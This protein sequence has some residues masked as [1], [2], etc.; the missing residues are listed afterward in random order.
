MCFN[1]LHFW[2]SP[3]FYF[4]LLGLVLDLRSHCL[5]N[6]NGF[7]FYSDGIEHSLITFSVVELLG[8]NNFREEEQDFSVCIF[9]NKIELIPY[10]LETEVIISLQLFELYRHFDIFVII[11][12]GH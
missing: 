3:S 8:E 5:R 4:L 2:W 7:C 10:M 9:V 1:C 6:N 12:A 11:I